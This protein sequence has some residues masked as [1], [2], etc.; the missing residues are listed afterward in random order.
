MWCEVF[1]GGCFNG[2]LKNELKGNWKKYRK[3]YPLKNCDILVITI[4][5]AHHEEFYFFN[6]RTNQDDFRS[7]VCCHV[8]WTKISVGLFISGSGQSKSFLP[9][10]SWTIRFHEFLDP[11]I[12]LHQF[13]GTNRFFISCQL[14]FFSPPLSPCFLTIIPSTTLFTSSPFFLSLWGPFFFLPASAVY[15]FPFEF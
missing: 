13:L 15:L 10:T 14:I 3:W 6:Y 11:G 4:K 12:R 7:L 8:V 1:V 2:N 9:S 5:K